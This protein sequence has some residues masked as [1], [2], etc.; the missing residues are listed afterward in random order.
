MYLN[1]IQGCSFFF[2]F[3][4]NFNTQ[5]PFLAPTT[6]K[7]FVC[8]LPLAFDTEHLEKFRWCPSY[9]S[10]D[11]GETYPSPTLIF[12]F[13]NILLWYVDSEK[14]SLFLL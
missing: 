7:N 11:L 9:G 8:Y 10:I 5:R 3:F 13:L 12:Y 14:F 4:F 1:G 2:Y 6:S